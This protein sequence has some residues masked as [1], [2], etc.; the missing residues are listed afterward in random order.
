MT[1]RISAILAMSACCLFLL[2][3]C[4]YD[5]ADIVYPPATACDTIAVKYASTV[6]PIL[7]RSCNA[8]H[9]GTAASGGGIKLDSYSSVLL[10]VTKGRLIGSISHLSGFSAMPQGNAKLP[11]CEILKISAWVTAGA[12]NN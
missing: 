4:Y 12:P 1:F 3:A 9:A 6:V 7:S 2:S 5:K 10:Q 8:C 11:S